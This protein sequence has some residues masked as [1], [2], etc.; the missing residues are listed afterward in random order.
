MK[1]FDEIYNEIKRNYKEVTAVKAE[2][3]AALHQWKSLVQ[4]NGRI[5]AK[6]TPETESKLKELEKAIYEAETKENDLLIASKFLKNNAKLA[7]FNDYAAAALEIW[8]KYA[9]KPLG[10]KTSAKIRSE[11]KCVTGCYFYTDCRYSTDGFTLSP[12][13]I[14]GNEY[15]VTAHTAYNS[16]NPVKMLVDNKVQAVR[17]EDFTV[18]YIKREYIENIPAA[19]KKA[20]K[21]YE[22]AVKAQQEFEKACSEYNALAVDGMPHANIR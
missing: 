9:G 18:S 11:I 17:L 7:L 10:E 5:K 8:N 15:N 1:K 22:K 6:E 20:K 2:K 4:N 14:M 16:G 13:D 12:A 19:V 3:E 21:L